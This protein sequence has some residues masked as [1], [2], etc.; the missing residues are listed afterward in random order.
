MAIHLPPP[1]LSPL[2]LR[3]SA[4]LP[5]E[6][7]SFRG[8]GAAADAAA[9]VVGYVHCDAADAADAD[10]PV[11][12]AAVVSDASADAAV[13]ACDAAAVDV[14]VSD[15]L[16]D[17][18]PQPARIAVT[19]AVLKTTDNNFFFM[20]SLLKNNVIAFCLHPSVHPVRT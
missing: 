5:S 20:F 17:D 6:T 2:F 11:A 7:G 19:I 14:A 16:V 9:A 8:G 15:V 12:A 1:P 3:S 13:A 4:L 10:V 18:D